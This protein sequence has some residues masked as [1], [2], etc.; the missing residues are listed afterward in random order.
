[1]SLVPSSLILFASLEH[2]LFLC[3][4]YYLWYS[5]IQ[6]HIGPLGPAA[7]IRSSAE[8]VVALKVGAS[9]TNTL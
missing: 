1:M 9:V 8:A 4:L 7:R 5:I 2:L 6:E 3:L